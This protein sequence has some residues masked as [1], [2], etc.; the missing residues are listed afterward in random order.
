MTSHLG[1]EKIPWLSLA[2]KQ[3]LLVVVEHV[4]KIIS[5]NYETGFPYF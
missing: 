4:L 3:K 5:K 2:N 1:L